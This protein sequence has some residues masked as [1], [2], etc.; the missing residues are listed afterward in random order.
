MQGVISLS[1]GGETRQCAAGHLPLPA[2]PIAQA[3]PSHMCLA[4][5]LCVPHAMVAPLAPSI[6]PFCIVTEAEKTAGYGGQLQKKGK[7]VSADGSGETW[8]EHQR[9][10]PSRAPQTS[11]T[12]AGSCWRCSGWGRECKQTRGCCKQFPSRWH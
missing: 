11:S 3:N 6:K 12:D 7:D 5:W 2:K 8:R 4:P 9:G 1:W 10:T